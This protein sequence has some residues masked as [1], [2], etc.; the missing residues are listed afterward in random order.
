MIHYIYAIVFFESNFVGC[1]YPQLSH[2]GEI[3]ANLVHEFNLTC[4][5]KIISKR[6]YDRFEFST[7]LTAFRFNLHL[8]LLG[9]SCS[10][11]DR[12]FSG[13][14]SYKLRDGSAIE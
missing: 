6:N 9:Y 11:I 13:K 5:K 14:M 7:F 3:Y 4:V 10:E 12:S 2:A 1:H 8:I